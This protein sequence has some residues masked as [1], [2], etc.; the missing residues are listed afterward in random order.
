MRSHHLLSLCC[1]LAVVAMPLR[2]QSPITNETI[3]HF[4]A[5]RTA[6]RPE[7]AKVST[8]TAE[9]DKRIKEWREC[10]A[11]LREVGQVTG[12][13]PSG[14]KMKAITRAKCG[15][16]SEDGFVEDRQKL[17]NA[18]EEVGARAAGMD[19][20][21]YRRVKEVATGFLGGD[22]NMPEGE[23][24]VLTARATD[25]SNA[26][27]IAYARA[28][29]GGRSGGGMGGALGNALGSQ[30]RMF[31]PDMTWA[32]VGYLNGLLYL[33]G[34]T[35]FETDYKP[36]EWTS[37]TITDA[38]QPDHK[39]IMER[40]ML[41]RDADRSERWRTKTITVS[42]EQADTIILESQMKPVGAD[43]LAMNVVRMRGRFPGDSAAKELMVPENMQT[44]SPQAFGRKP[45]PESIAGA[46]VG[47]E[48]IRVNGTAYVA[49]HVQFGSGGGNMDWWLS[50][51]APGGLVRITS[52]AN[53]K[54]GMWTMEMTGSGTG[55]R[56]ELGMK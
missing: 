48:T 6:E 15:A 45:T 24:T 37:W 14:F 22:R 31:T 44:V 5:G 13:S 11:Q 10:Y 41:R 43:G 29:R 33:S 4:I 56:S 8:Q 30:M 54:E 42:P 50:D 17:L 32:Y 3:D 36:G 12:T 9:L 28:E 1:A 25:L 35:M 2:A 40:A 53:G 38:S 19:V 55:A 34:A 51:R 23:R 39:T 7:L 20:G 52:T 26:L 16:T 27:G 49:K 21:E 18:P 46:T 47:T